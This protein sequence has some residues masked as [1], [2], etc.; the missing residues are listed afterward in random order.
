MAQSIMQNSALQLTQLT[1]QLNN[2]NTTTLSNRNKPSK[3]TNNPRDEWVN[4]RSPLCTKTVYK[5]NKLTQA[6]SDE[7]TKLS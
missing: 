6:I 5:K 1:Q 4:E 3:E 2:S 7:M